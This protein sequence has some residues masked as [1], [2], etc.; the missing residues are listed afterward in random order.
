MISEKSINVIKRSRRF[1]TE[2]QVLEGAIPVAAEVDG[3]WLAIDHEGYFERVNEGGMRAWSPTLQGVI[4]LQRIADE[5]AAERRFQFIE[6]RQLRG[7]LPI[8]R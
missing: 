7:E 2:K 8:R 1:R 4:Y 5:V 6:T 3:V